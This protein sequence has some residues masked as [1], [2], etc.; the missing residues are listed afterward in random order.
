MVFK[1]RIGV[2]ISIGVK[3]SS[4]V[5][6]HSFVCVQCQVIYSMYCDKIVILVR[7]WHFQREVTS[8]DQFP[9]GEFLG[10]IEASPN[11]IRSGSPILR[12]EGGSNIWL[13][14]LSGLIATPLFPLKCPICL[15]R[16]KRALTRY[17]GRCDQRLGYFHPGW[18]TL[19]WLVMGG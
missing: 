13:M 16:L 6:V 2:K 5:S 1:V 7:R 17:D 14:G 9:K 18:L 11:A 15:S 8:S 19:Q 12:K 10:G 3:V 4:L